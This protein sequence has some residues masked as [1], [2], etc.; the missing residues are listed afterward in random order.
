MA[1]Y[2]YVGLCRAIY[3]YVGPCRGMYGCAW[4]CIAI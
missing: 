2:G 4:L 3:C 1:G